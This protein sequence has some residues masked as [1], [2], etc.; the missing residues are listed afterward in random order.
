[1]KATEIDA[2]ALRVIDQVVSGKPNEDSRVELK[3]DWPID[4]SKAARRIAGHANAAR[5]DPILWL[6]GV[7]QATGVKKCTP[8]DPATWFAGVTVRRSSM[9]QRRR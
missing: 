2:W 7:D 8:M 6:I 3:A 5:G 1:M 4:Y 9:D